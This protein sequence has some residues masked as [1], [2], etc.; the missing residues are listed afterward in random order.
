MEKDLKDWHAQ[1]WKPGQAW[2]KM[3]TFRFRAEPA[4]APLQRKNVRTGQTVPNNQGQKEHEQISNC[5]FLPYA[6]L[7]LGGQ[8]GHELRFAYGTTDSTGKINAVCDSAFYIS[9]QGGCTLSAVSSVEWKQGRGYD[10]AYTHYWKA[11]YDKADTYPMK[12][13]K[14][15]LGCAVNGTGRSPETSHLWRVRDPESTNSNA[16]SRTRC[17]SLWPT[18]STAG[19]ECDEYPFQ[20]AGNR[21]AVSDFDRNLSVCAMPRAHNGGAGGVL[22]RLYLRDRVLIGDGYFNRFATQLTSPPKMADLCWKPINTGSDYYN[23][24]IP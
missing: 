1:A 11:C 12:P 20:S 16:R 5:E 8:L 6:H 24:P 22:N 18:Y 19:Q 7:G 2:S 14:I 3:A 23:P 13:S 9:R 15:I 17:H 10:I 21:N 4:H